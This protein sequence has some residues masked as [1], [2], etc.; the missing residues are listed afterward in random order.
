MPN[1]RPAHHTPF[2]C[3]CIES[4]R[5]GGEFNVHLNESKLEKFA[6][7]IARQTLRRVPPPPK[8][9][10][11]SEDDT[12]ALLLAVNAI[13]FWYTIYTCAF[14]KIN[15]TLF[16]LM[17]ISKHHSLNITTLAHSILAAAGGGSL[18]DVFLSAQLLRRLR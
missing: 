6:E 4:A 7:E 16:S 12:I 10:K 13:N 14:P 9:S 11:H 8:N 1:L 15:N 3:S 2:P 5:S 17:R 18:T